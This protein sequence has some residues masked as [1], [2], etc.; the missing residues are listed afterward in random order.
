MIIY[1]LVYLFLKL[2]KVSRINKFKTLE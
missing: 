2:G 1:N